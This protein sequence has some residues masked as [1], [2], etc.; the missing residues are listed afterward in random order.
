MASTAGNSEV[1]DDFGQRRP[2]LEYYEYP[3]MPTVLD[4]TLVTLRIT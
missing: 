3:P 2:D 1:D 4:G